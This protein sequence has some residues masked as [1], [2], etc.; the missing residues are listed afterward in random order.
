MNIITICD[1]MFRLT[2]QSLANTILVINSLS[3]VSMIIYKKINPDYGGKSVG[4]HI[5]ITTLKLTNTNNWA[6]LWCLIITSG[7][8]KLENNS[9]ISLKW[10]ILQTS[11]H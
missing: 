10:Y 8:T 3:I 5:S 7:I 2:F 11:T 1:H 4:L 9:G 6:C